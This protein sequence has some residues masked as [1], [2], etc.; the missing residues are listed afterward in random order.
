M[1]SELFSVW[2]AQ[3]IPPYHFNS[4][5][6]WANKTEKFRVAEYGGIKENVQ[7]IVGERYGYG[8]SIGGEEGFDY[9]TGG[10]G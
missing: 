9:P 3:P 6:A 7:I 2:L 10:S 8:Y 4:F 1:S 5:D